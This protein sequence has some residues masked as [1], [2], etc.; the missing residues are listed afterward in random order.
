MVGKRLSHYK[1]EAETLHDRI[2]KGP[3]NPEEAV[4]IASAI[5]SAVIRIPYTI[6]YH[7]EWHLRC[8]YIYQYSA[9][10]GPMYLTYMRLE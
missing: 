4:R 7:W 10:K 3:L 9:Q 5:A 8:Q 6:V 2:Q 1:I